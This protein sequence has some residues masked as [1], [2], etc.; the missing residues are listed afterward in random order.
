M[1]VAARAASAAAAS[2]QD[3]YVGGSLSIPVDGGGNGYGAGQRAWAGG[4][5]AAVGMEAIGAEAKTAIAFRND[6]SSNGIGA[7]N[8]DAGGCESGFGRFLGALLSERPLG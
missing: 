2:T 3:W 5:P 8:V 7:V 4:M 6:D 1:V